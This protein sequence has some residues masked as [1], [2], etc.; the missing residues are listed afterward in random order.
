MKKTVGVVDLVFPKNK[1]FVVH[2]PADKDIKTLSDQVNEFRI[3]SL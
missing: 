1:E 3:L 2:C